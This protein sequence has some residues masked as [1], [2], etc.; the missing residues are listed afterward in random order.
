MVRV[1]DEV[2][3]LWSG[4]GM[5]AWGSGQGQVGVSELRDG[6]RPQLLLPMS[7]S[8]GIAPPITIC[9]HPTTSLLACPASTLYPTPNLRGP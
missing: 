6:A 1:R 3:W 2:L 9:P 7:Q 4:S 8:G 5:R